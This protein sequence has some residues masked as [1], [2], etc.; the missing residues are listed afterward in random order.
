ME[1]VLLTKVGMVIDGIVK[2][3]YLFAGSYFIRTGIKYVSDYRESV[4]RERIEN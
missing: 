1:F 3:G 4:A 2:L